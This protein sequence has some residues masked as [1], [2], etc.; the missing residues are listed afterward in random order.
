MRRPITI[1][2][3]AG[4]LFTGIV[5][6]FLHFLFDLSGES[7]LVSLFSAVNESIWEHIKLLFYPML[8]FSVAEFRAWG[9]DRP[10][11]WQ[12]KLLGTLFGMALIPAIYYT[13]T[14]SLGVSA[15]WFNITIFFIAAGSVYWLETVLFQKNALWALS[16]AWAIAGLV[17]LCI[18][19]SLLTFFPP[20]IPLF[21][22]PVTGRYGYHLF[23]AERVKLWFSHIG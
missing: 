11:F 1:Y 3:L 7:I 21:R 10:D 16:S 18:L 19:F 13:Y 17:L 8:L 14:G 6:T 20:H 12:I 23:Q 2:Q 15:D 9:R 4:F 5:G 22:D